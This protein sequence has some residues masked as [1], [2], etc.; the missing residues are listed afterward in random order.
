MTYLLIEKRIDKT[1]WLRIVAALF[2]TLVALAAIVGLIALSSRW[3]LPLP[4]A[5]ALV[6]VPA[7]VFPIYIPAKVLSL[8]P[9]DPENQH[10]Q[11][12]PKKGFLKTFHR[13]VTNEYKTDRW[14][15]F[16]IQGDRA[17]F[18]NDSG[19]E[20]NIPYELYPGNLR[21]GH[22]FTD[23]SDLRTGNWV[24]RSELV[25]GRIVFYGYDIWKNRRAKSQG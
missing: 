6:V 18:R 4:L 20:L 8:L 17:I 25:N 11:F 7:L 22:S 10:I 13:G 2:A 19:Q 1:S 15:T 14:S 23:L 5:L 16:S 12:N 24:V 3:E 21:T 9:M